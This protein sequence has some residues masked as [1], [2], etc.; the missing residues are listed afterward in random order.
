MRF[1]RDSRTAG[2][3]PVQLRKNNTFLSFHEISKVYLVRLVFLQHN[4]K[5]NFC[6]NHLNFLLA[7]RDNVPYML[8]RINAS[9][10][11][12]HQISLSRNKINVGGSAWTRIR[13]RGHT[14]KTSLLF[15]SAISDMKPPYDH[16]SIAILLML[17]IWASKSIYFNKLASY[18]SV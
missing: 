4:L 11:Q 7:I 6:H 10:L 5:L 15:A 14:L 13:G 1:Y 18:F 12:V 3:P 8:Y 17:S 9:L 2:R 16:P